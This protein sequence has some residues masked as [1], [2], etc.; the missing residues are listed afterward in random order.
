MTVGPID[1]LVETAP[2]ILRPETQ[3]R[4]AA[5]QLAD[6]GTASAPVTDDTGSLLGILTQKDCF[7]PALLASYY[8]EWNGCVGDVM[9]AT[10][11]T[12]DLGT[13]MVSAAEAFLELPFRSFPILDKDRLV[14]ML[15]RETV[16]RALIKAG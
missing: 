1:S 6:T 8:R 10:P 5:A 11:A 15:H 16:F 12:L 14:G 7:R 9:S 2:L 13:D 3:I 4:R